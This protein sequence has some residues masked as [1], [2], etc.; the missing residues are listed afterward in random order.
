MRPVTLT[1]T[2]GEGHLPGSHTLPGNG[3]KTSPDKGSFLER[4]QNHP[5]LFPALAAF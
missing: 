5:V 2:D 3:E 1:W 4:E